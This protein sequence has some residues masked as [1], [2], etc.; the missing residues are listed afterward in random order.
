MNRIPLWVYI[1]GAILLLLFL[2]SKEGLN[3]QGWGAGPVGIF[4]D[5]DC[6]TWWG[7]DDWST[8]GYTLSDLPDQAA[9]EITYGPS[10][11][12]GIDLPPRDWN[13]FKSGDTDSHEP[14]T[15]SFWVVTDDEAQGI[16]PSFLNVLRKVRYLDEDDSE[17]FTQWLPRY[18][19]YIINSIV[20]RVC[21]V[22]CGIKGPEI[23]KCDAMPV[24][25]EEV[26]EG[27]LQGTVYDQHVYDFLQQLK[28]IDISDDTLDPLTY[29]QIC[30]LGS[31]A[32]NRCN[33]ELCPGAGQPSPSTGC[34]GTWALEGC[35]TECGPGKRLEIYTPPPGIDGSDCQ[36]GDGKFSVRISETEC[37]NQP[38]TEQ[39]PCADDPNSIFINAYG[40]FTSDTVCVGFASENDLTPQE[41]CE[42][43]D[44]ILG[45]L[46][47][48]CPSICD[49]ACLD[50]SSVGGGGA[51]QPVDDDLC[52]DDK[53]RLLANAL[54]S[55]SEFLAASSAEDYSGS[56]YETADDP[57][58][59]LVSQQIF[60]D[61]SGPFPEGYC[62]WHVVDSPLFNNLSEEEKRILQPEGTTVTWENICPSICNDCCVD[63]PDGS[64]SG[65]LAA[66][67]Y[68]LQFLNQGKS[69]C[70]VMATMVENSGR[71][72]KNDACTVPLS[73]FSA[74]PLTSQDFSPAR[75]VALVGVET[76]LSQYCPSLCGPRPTD[77]CSTGGS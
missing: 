2:N 44:P 40:G 70:Q 18:L 25:W 9:Q 62:Q 5:T 54:I 1:V 76:T 42:S 28:E 65:I 37:D 58:G 74:D 60:H 41:L 51:V 57:C 6:V 23:G 19:N 11:Q 39:D 24:N 38:C 16:C 68:L 61:P 12:T 30:P 46:S 59:Y 77:Q 10:E 7:D 34:N 67:P 33:P 47:D 64:L 49:N 26:G 14:G 43:T 50:S 17:L 32:D 73:E 27:L 29:G 35:T 75:S 56:L 71:G 31:L 15:I 8:S 69:A 45:S 48:Y 4:G 3:E 53:E 21:A 63:D 55:M 52:G 13:D 22:R 36:Y 66:D 72:L 20:K